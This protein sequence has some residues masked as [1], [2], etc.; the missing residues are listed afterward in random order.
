MCTRLKHQ[1]NQ[2]K[3]ALSDKDAKIEELQSEIKKINLL[4]QE[5]KKE[6]ENIKI[7]YKKTCELYE[8]GSKK[9]KYESDS[10]IGRLEA[11]IKELKDSIE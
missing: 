4:T 2:G 7:D 8:C 5:L 3:K 9:L 6:N 1:I 10:E 11:F